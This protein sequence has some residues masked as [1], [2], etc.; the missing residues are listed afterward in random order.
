[1]DSLQK[2]LLQFCLCHS[3]MLSYTAE[4]PWSHA[5]ITAGIWIPKG[6]GTLGR[7]FH[8]CITQGR[9]EKTSGVSGSMISSPC[10]LSAYVIGHLFHMLESIQACHPQFLGNSCQLLDFKTSALFHYVNIKT[11]GT[12]LYIYIMLVGMYMSS[13]FLPLHQT[14]LFPCLTKKK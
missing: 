14:D 8:C 2:L 6:N 1:M 12:C 7:V 9:L 3:A 5:K 10:H 13:S 11:P 4:D